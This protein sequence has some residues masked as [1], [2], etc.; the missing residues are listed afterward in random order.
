[1]N[2]FVWWGIHAPMWQLYSAMTV[3]VFL[4]IL[5]VLPSIMRAIKWGKKDHAMPP[6]ES[7]KIAVVDREEAPSHVSVAIN[8]NVEATQKQF[9]RI[10]QD[11]S[12][13]RTDCSA[14]EISV[15]SAIN[16]F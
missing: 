3:S 12:G 2:S 4:L 14:R 15:A 13:T 10:S 11:E 6:S 16:Q 9:D 7:V 5:I 8:A 1:M